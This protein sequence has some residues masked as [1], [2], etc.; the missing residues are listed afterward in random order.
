[1]TVAELK[2]LK[3]IAET[4]YLKRLASELKAIL[5]NQGK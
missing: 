2:K 3:E 1:M 5:A 4:V